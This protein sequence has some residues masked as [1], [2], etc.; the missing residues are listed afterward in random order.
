[1]PKHAD[2]NNFRVVLAFNQPVENLH[3]RNVLYTL[4]CFGS[5]Q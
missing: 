3:V 1:V 2:L 5:P 4:N